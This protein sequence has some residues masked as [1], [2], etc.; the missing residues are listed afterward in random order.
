MAERDARAFSE[1]HDRTAPWAYGVALKVLGDEVR[2]QEALLDAYERLWQEAA[3]LTETAVSPLVWLEIA[4]ARVAKVEAGV[5][6]HR[7]DFRT[8]E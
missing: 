8:S 2:A 7:E 5:I 1:L 3:S 4:L 6:A